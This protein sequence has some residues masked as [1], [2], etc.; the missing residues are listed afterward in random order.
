VH[1]ALTP[2]NHPVRR[3]LP[4]PPSL[5][6]PRSQHPLPPTCSAV[7]RCEFGARYPW[8]ARRDEF[9]GALARGRA[10]TTGVAPRRRERG[11]PRLARRPR[12]RRECGRPGHGGTG[13]KP[14]P[15]RRRGIKP[16]RGR[17][18]HGCSPRPQ[19]RWRRAAPPVPRREQAR[20]GRGT[21]I[22]D[23]VLPTLLFRQSYIL[24]YSGEAIPLEYNLAGLN[25]ISF[26]KGCYIGQEL[27]A[28][29]H[30][31]GVIQKRLMPMKFVDRNGQGIIQIF[32]W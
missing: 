30:H 18:L 2:V 9:Q 14:Q 10:G 4:L 23:L 6:C 3:C 27:I 11:R 29:L 7:S 16:W 13:P 21:S 31:R 19:T 22:C 28:W 24:F 8:K 17:P 25:A 5:R 15:W 26:E 1:R 20:R 32:L 12:P